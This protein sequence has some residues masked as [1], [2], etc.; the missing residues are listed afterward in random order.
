MA[1]FMHDP[2]LD[3][4]SLPL[5][6]TIIIKER[7]TKAYLDEMGIDV[8]SLESALEAGEQAAAN[9]TSYAPKTGAGM[10]RWITTV[11]TARTLLSEEGWKPDDKAN[12][13]TAK[14]PDSRWTLAFVGGDEYVGN[15]DGNAVP[16][17]ARPKGPATAEA[18]GVQLSLDIPPQKSHLTGSS[19]DH[20]MPPEGEW[21]FLYYRAEEEIR[22]EVSFPSG[23][24]D[25]QFTGW[26]V[27]VLLPPIPLADATAVPDVGGGDVEFKVENAEFKA[28]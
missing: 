8:M 9:T 2:S 20:D 5:G 28:K 6:Q 1:Q 15:P 10:R 21:V 18:V 23:F 16:K 24:D 4:R 25:G 17:A 13:P 19:A 22:S 12:R 11:E 26:R 14:S 27:R 7:D 3:S